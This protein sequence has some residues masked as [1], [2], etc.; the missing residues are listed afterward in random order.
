MSWRLARVLAPVALLATLA[1]D[2]TI[3]VIQIELAEEP[4]A[5]L[6]ARIDRVRVELATTP[7]SPPLVTEATRRSGGGLALDLEIPASAGTGQISLEA[8]ANDAMIGIAQSPPLPLGAIDGTLTLYVAAPFSVGAATV[9]LEPPRA[10]VSVVPLTFGAVLLGGRGAD[11][12]LV[13][14]V[15]VYNVYDH[16]FQ[17]GADLPRARAGSAA[18]SSARGVVYLMGGSDSAG[19]ISAPVKFDT[20]IAPAGAYTDLIAPAGL[21]RDGVGAASLG[22]EFGVVGGTPAVQ[23]SGELDRVDVVDGSPS[24]PGTLTGSQTAGTFSAI[25]VGDGTGSSGAAKVEVGMVSALD[26][27]TSLLRIRHGAAVDPTGDIFV[28]GGQDSAGAPLLSGLRFRASTQDFVELAD[29]LTAPRM[30]AAIAI[31]DRFI[32][33][34]GGVD[35]LELVLSDVL[36]I[37]R[38][39]LELVITSSL[40]VGRTGAKAVAMT[41]GQVMIV[42]GRDSA[43][44]VIGVVELFTPELMPELRREAASAGRMAPM[45]ARNRHFRVR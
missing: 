31:T 43:G 39:S 24:Y 42:G 7:N 9:A 26:G 8:F 1:C 41:N 12:A 17:V 16:A 45:Y 30:D 14:D 36:V 44:D 11:G 15:D 28:I 21:E 20:N 37:D 34:A 2:G 5:G 27:P 13:A 19:A 40:I 18:F 6:L 10:E 32:I 23:I 29:L 38:V 33:I 22:G 25:A 4:G 35:E 3:G